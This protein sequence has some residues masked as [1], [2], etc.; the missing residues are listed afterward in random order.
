MITAH[1]ASPADL[2]TVVTLTRNAFAVYLP[3]LGN[4]PVPVTED[5]VPRIARSEV[6]LFRDEDALAGLCVVE[7]HPDHLM[8]FSIAVAPS[9]QGK[10]YG[11]QMLD[12]LVH[13]ARQEKV[14]EVRLYT[15][16]VMTRNYALYQRF[17]FVE[18]GRRPNPIRP[19]F[20]VIDMALRV[21]APDE[22]GKT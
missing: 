13:K 19:E 12:W 8:L 3:V 20:T 22:Q 16:I 4:P 14:G 17:G 9:K 21:D 10:G 1:P 7:R 11:R 15:N 5:Y 2:E 18:T 6:W